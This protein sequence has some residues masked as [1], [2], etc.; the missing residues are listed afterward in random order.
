LA[1]V[2]RQKLDE[3]IRNYGK[4]TS[5]MMNRYVMINYLDTGIWIGDEKEWE[6]IADILKAKYK[7]LGY[8]IYRSR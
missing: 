6:G 5:E 7:E 1:D 2:Y 3:Y 8:E 4:V